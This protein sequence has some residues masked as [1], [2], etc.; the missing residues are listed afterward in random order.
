VRVKA[1]TA[2][3]GPYHSLIEDFARRQTGGLR[4][5]QGVSEAEIERFFQIF[6]AAEDAALAPKLPETVEEAS[7]HNIVPLPAAHVEIDDLAREL[8][9]MPVQQQAR[10]RARQ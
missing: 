10:A 3:M 6:L 8:D 4:F 7:V 2:L 1:S 9:G 5:L